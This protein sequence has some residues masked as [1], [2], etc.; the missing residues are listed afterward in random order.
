MP[1]DVTLCHTKIYAKVK[2]FNA[3]TTHYLYKI[4][5]QKTGMAQD[6]IK[7]IPHTLIGTLTDHV[8][9]GLPNNIMNTFLSSPSQLP[10]QLI[11]PS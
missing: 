5:R 2:C 1:T 4:K 10:E 8:P 6:H 7:V 3:G 11:A 9:R